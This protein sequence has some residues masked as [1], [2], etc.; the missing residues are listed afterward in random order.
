MDDEKWNCLHLDEFL[1]AGGRVHLA[2]YI[3][4]KLGVFGG[5]NSFSFGLCAS[6]GV[7]GFALLHLFSRRTISEIRLLKTGDYVEIKFFNAFWT[8]QTKLIHCSEF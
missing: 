5:W 7:G 8:P 3:V 2:Q 1:L 6:L 4:T